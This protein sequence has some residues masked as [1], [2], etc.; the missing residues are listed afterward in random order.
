MP[1]PATKFSP[2]SHTLPLST[3]L[4]RYPALHTLLWGAHPPLAHVFHGTDVMRCTPH[5]SLDVNDCCDA[6][7]ALWHHS[8]LSPKAFAPT[9]SEAALL[10]LSE[11][12]LGPH[13]N[14]APGKPPGVSTAHAW[15]WLVVKDLP[16]GDHAPIA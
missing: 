3:V 11:C 16:Q 13:G 10:G 15:D 6:L 9:H 4:S 14:C 2:P 7:L 12:N 8:Y 1:H 5:A